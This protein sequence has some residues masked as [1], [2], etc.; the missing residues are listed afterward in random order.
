MTGNREDY[1]KA[2]YE[3]GGEKNRIGTKEIA[4]ALNISPRDTTRR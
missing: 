2:I 1:I 3:L 4:M